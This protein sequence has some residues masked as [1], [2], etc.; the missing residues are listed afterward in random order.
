MIEVTGSDKYRQC[1]KKQRHHFAY[2]GPCSQSYVFPVAMHE[3]E[4][5]TPKKAECPRIDAFKL[6]C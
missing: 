4:S 6:W 2:K 5:W 1:I 3:C